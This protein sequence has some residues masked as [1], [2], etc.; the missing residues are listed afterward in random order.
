MGGGD[1]DRCGAEDGGEGDGRP[2]NKELPE[3]FI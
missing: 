3:E 1:A 2:V